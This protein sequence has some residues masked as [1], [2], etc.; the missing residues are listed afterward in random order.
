MSIVQDLTVGLRQ[1]FAKKSQATIITKRDL[2]ERVDT[3]SNALK[4]IIDIPLTI[5]PKYLIKISEDIKADKTKDPFFD[6]YKEFVGGFQQRASQYE[7]VNAMITAFEVAQRLH[8]T[9]SHLRPK[10]DK[11][12]EDKVNINNARFSHMAILGVVDICEIY[13][14]FVVNLYQ[15]I[16]CTVTKDTKELPK[17]RID[18]VKANMAMCTAVV[19]KVYDRTGPVAFESSLVEIRNANNDIPIMNED[20][21]PNVQF[22]NE[23]RIGLTTANLLGISLQN[24]FLV[25]G[26]F[27]ADWQKYRIVKIERQ[28]E[29]MESR[30]ALVKM[31][32]DGVDKD[33]PEYLK[34]QKTVAY[35][36]E[37]ITQIDR[38][39]AKYYEE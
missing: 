36:E 24:P 2:N 34:L 18:Y 30:T 33:S 9:L 16:F 19:N 29:W 28:R 25:L 37:K 20:G 38:K 35:Y 17:Y 1:I 5:G 3:V 6:A 7:R 8:S 15:G 4:T 14:E 11:Y 12:F 27:Y 10:I 26:K 21:L 23:A 13:A 39:L 31:S 32:M 22:L